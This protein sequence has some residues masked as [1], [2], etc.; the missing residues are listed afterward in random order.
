MTKSAGF[1]RDPARPPLPETPLERSAELYESV[2]RENP[3]LY[4]LDVARNQ[5]NTA[6][7]RAL[8]GRL[9][10]ALACVQR[11]ETLLDRPGPVWPALF[12]D[13]ACVYSICSTPTP[14]SVPTVV[15]RN[16]H[17]KRAVAALRRAI[18]SGYHDL[19]Q[20]RQDPLL[21]PIRRRHDFQELLM[22]LTFPANPFQR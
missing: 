16:S 4:R 2:A 5:L 7:Q 15:E 19:G 18:A 9:E 14:C 20:I 10:Q 17:A 11:A 8:T 3:V 22:D 21:D 12:Y 13:L 1:A 6:F